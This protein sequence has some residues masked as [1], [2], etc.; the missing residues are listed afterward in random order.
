M[1]TELNA[2]YLSTTQIRGV[3][4]SE[5]HK[6]EADRQGQ[7]VDPVPRRVSGLTGVKTASKATDGDVSTSFDTNA[8]RRALRTSRGAVSGALATENS[9]R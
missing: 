8:V 6:V 5:N 3:K 9:D 1:S 7:E 2:L 4:T